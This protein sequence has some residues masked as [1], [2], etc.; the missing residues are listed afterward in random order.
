M[1]AGRLVGFFVAVALCSFVLAG[2]GGGKSAFETATISGKVTHHDGKPLTNA[3]II[4]LA[5]QLGAEINANLGPDGTYSTQMPV[6]VGNYQVRVT[7]PPVIDKADGSP[8]PKPIENA[9]FPKKARDF[10][11][12]GLTATI[13]AGKNEFNFDLKD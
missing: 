5:P 10:A 9:D 13:K 3:T 6:K 7:P 4:F 2:C 1:R 8:P 12:S 11:T